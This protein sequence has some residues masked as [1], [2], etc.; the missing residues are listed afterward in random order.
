MVS[1]VNFQLLTP[2]SHYRLLKDEFRL[3]NDKNLNLPGHLN[4]LKVLV[5]LKPLK[6]HDDDLN[7]YHLWKNK[8]SH[9][10]WKGLFSKEVFV[11]LG[12]T[13]SRKTVSVPCED[14]SRARKILIL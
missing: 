11:E 14:A 6:V 7:I 13:K 8:Q 4:E 12:D 1:Q 10:F 2:L 5:Q 9:Y 3:I